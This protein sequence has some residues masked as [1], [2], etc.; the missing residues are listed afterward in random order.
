MPDFC[1]N[2]AV[3]GDSL[4]YGNADAGLEA[5]RNWWRSIA[6]RFLFKDDQIPDGVR[7]KLC[8]RAS[9]WW[10]LCVNNALLRC[11]NRGLEA[12]ASTDTPGVAPADGAASAP[13]PR[14]P[15]GVPRA[16]VVA[17]DQHSVG[18]SAMCFAEFYLHLFAEC[19][20]DAS[21]R[22]H[23]DVS[24]ALVASG[25]NETV[26]LL[27]APFNVHYGPWDC[28][29]FWHQLQGATD[30]FQRLSSYEAPLFQPLLLGIA[31][32]RGDP[33]SI[34]TDAAWQEDRWRDMFDGPSTQSKGPKVA[35]CRW[36]GWVKSARYWDRW[37]HS[38]LCIMLASGMPLGFITGT[39]SSASLKLD[40]SGKT[41]EDGK[42][43]TMKQAQGTMRSVRDRAKNTW[44]VATIIMMGPALQRAPRCILGIWHWRQNSVVRDPRASVDFFTEQA[45]GGCSQLVVEMCARLDDSE[46]LSYM[47]ILMHPHDLP[48]ADS[49]LVTAIDEEEEWTMR[50]VTL[51]LCL[52]SARLKSCLWHAD[53]YFGRAAA[54]LGPARAREE[55]LACDCASACADACRRNPP[56]C[57]GA[58][59]RSFMQVAIVQHCMSLAAAEDYSCVSPALEAWVRSLFELGQ[60][61][62]IEDL[63]KRLRVA[64]TRGQ[65]SKSVKPERA[66][67]IGI[68]R[69][70]L[71]IVHRY[72]EVDYKDCPQ[73]A[74]QRD[75]PWRP[76]K[77]HYQPGSSKPAVP[78]YEIVSQQSSGTRW[79]SYTPQSQALQYDTYRC[80]GLARAAWVPVFLLRGLL[81]RRRDD[82]W[83]LSL[84]VAQQ[85]VAIGWTMVSANFDGGEYCTCERRVGMPCSS[86]CSWLMCT[87]ASEWSAMPVQW[88]NPSLRIA[89]PVGLGSD[90]SITTG[91]QMALAAFAPLRMAS[92][93]RSWSWQP[94]RASGVLAMPPSRCFARPSAWTSPPTWRHSIGPFTCCSSPTM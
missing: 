87:G 62:L 81:V 22:V 57:R 78:C 45:C 7:R 47:G 41:T 40:S 92:R 4:W 67:V 82:P 24:A 91:R 60:T 1:K 64:E 75:L 49:A 85:N 14:R 2:S 30:E 54:L 76:E 38:Q 43:T 88:L 79:A 23:N 42:R 29:A 69:S 21:H 25:F 51:L 19:I 84:G 93:S 46:M 39:H 55:T 3:V 15:D 27:V 35:L 20:F 86:C 52:L 44:H 8:R 63:F 37:W 59:A 89:H 74:S 16:L 56:F 61:K 6:R 73:G 36:F 72:P 26:Y 90:N 12:F 18:W 11:S 5:E 17:C 68:A 32:D 83:S 28:A 70:V 77:S 66:R 10:L 48:K 58:I 13:A 33:P 53:G 65:N 34:I 94:W 80:S 50:V 31:K 9:M 71:N